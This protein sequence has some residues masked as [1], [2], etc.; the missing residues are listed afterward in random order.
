LT[1]S[2]YYSNLY[3][4]THITVSIIETD[5][6]RQISFMYDP[7]PPLW[8]FHYKTPEELEQKLCDC[9]QQFV[10]TKNTK[11]S[12]MSI[13][14]NVEQIL[15]SWIYYGWITLRPLTKG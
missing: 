2:P 5:L 9:M 14:A 10:N 1:N 13:K 11:Y 15:N 12:R 3:S 7:P 4:T 8:I 6:G